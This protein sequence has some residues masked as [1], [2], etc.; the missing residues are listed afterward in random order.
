M[1]S[2]SNG[3]AAQRSGVATFRRV[4][5]HRL[6]VVQARTTRVERL[7]AAVGLP[8]GACPILK[9]LSGQEAR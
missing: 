7:R 4:A 1:S 8:L 2:P 9:A 5:Q 3:Q 6:D